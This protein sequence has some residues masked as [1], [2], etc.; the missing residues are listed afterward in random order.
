MN[1]A[2]ILLVLPVL[3]G[4]SSADTLFWFYTLTEPPPGWEYEWFT[5]GPSGARLYR[6][7]IW[8]PMH[9]GIGDRTAS[10]C[11]TDLSEVNCGF[12]NSSGPG[13]YQEAGYLVTE[14]IVVPYGL[15]SLVLYVPQYTSISAS[16]ESG[17]SKVELYAIVNGVSQLLWSRYVSALSNVSLVDTLPIEEV[18]AELDPGDSIRFRFV[19]SYGGW[20]ASTTID[21]RLWDAELTGCG[22]L[23]FIQ[24]TW[25]SIKALCR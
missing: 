15:D 17:S 12:A 5:F 19:G 8:Y 20:Y 16:G 21:W 18:V 4:L 3:V 14:T 13:L 25:G 1:F 10:S 2:A 9:E 6:R 11:I 24:S 23:G 7:A 22:D